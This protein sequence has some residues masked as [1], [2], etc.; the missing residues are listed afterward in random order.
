MV[1]A[2]YCTSFIRRVVKQIVIFIECISLLSTAYKI[3][4][5]I[6]LS[7]LAVYVDKIVWDLQYGFQCNSSSTSLIFCICQMCE[8]KQEYGEAWHKL[9][10]GF[11]RGYVLVR[12]NVLY[13]ILFEFGIPMKLCLYETY[14]K[15]W[16]GILP[17]LFKFSIEHTIRKVQLY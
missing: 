1:E 13:N 2:S 5:S 10:I 8:K 14:N 12:R 15:V 9:C 7:R 16:A 4:S 17:R 11:V 3:V 6:L